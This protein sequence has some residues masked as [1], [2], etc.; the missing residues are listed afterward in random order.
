M[1][2]AVDETDPDIENGSVYLLSCNNHLYVAR[3]RQ[4]IDGSVALWVERGQESKMPSDKINVIYKILMTT[5][6]V[7]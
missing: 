7:V 6:R 3:L 1:C 2:L 5:K 4:E